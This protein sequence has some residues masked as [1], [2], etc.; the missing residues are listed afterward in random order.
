MSS[1]LLWWFKDHQPKGSGFHP[2]GP[3][4]LQSKMPPHPSPSVP[5]HLPPANSVSSRCPT[6]QTSAL[7]VLN[8]LPVS[9]TAYLYCQLQSPWQQ[10]RDEPVGAAAVPLQ[11][12][13]QEQRGGRHGAVQPH[14][15]PARGEARPLCECVCVCARACACECL[16]GMCVCVCVCV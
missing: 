9:L 11:G 15:V 10:R 16:C 7:N 12:D 6:P 1:S 5:K 4:A 3:D 2:Y 8:E 14:P 13:L